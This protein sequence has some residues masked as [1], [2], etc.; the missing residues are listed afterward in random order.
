MKLIY[1]YLVKQLYDQ[2][3]RNTMKQVE[4]IFKGTMNKTTSTVIYFVQNRYD[5]INVQQEYNLNKNNTFIISVE[6]NKKTYI[7]RM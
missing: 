1:K 7:N 2:E 6:N 3:Q 4:L 5:S